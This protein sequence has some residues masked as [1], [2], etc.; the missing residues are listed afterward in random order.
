MANGEDKTVA[1]RFPRLLVSI[2][3]MCDGVNTD[4]PLRFAKWKMQNA[5]WAALECGMRTAA[6]VVDAARALKDT[7]Q[8]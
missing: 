2:S 3:D 1:E 7:T 4:D 8:K 5:A 6:E